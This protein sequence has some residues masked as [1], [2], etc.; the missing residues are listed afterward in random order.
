MDY[1]ADD[2]AGMNVADV[3]L[4]L[5]QPSTKKV[6]SFSFLNIIFILLFSH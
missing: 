6:I 2:D 1:E 5:G 4:A 3:L